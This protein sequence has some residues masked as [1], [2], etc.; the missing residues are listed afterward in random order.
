MDELESTAAEMALLDVIA[1]GT[2]MC[3]Y[4]FGVPAEGNYGP[5]TCNQG[6]REEP[7]TTS[8]PYPIFAFPHHVRNI[9]I[10]MVERTLEHCDNDHPAVAWWKENTGE[11]LLAGGS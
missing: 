9:Q 11:D 6:C 4:L 1:G 2:P 5:K 8:G 3:P 7:C 10:L